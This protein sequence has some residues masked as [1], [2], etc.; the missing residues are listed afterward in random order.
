M[1]F[2]SLQGAAGTSSLPGM[3]QAARTSQ[4]PVL[5]PPAMV[6]LPLTT[7]LVGGRRDVGLWLLE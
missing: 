7:A 6:M 5:L 1:G 2:E 4:H 3:C